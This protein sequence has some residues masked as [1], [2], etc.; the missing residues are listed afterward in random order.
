[1]FESD[2]SDMHFFKR[3]LESYYCIFILKVEKFNQGVILQ[4]NKLWVGGAPNGSV[5]LPE[6]HLFFY[7]VAVHVIVCR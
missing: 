2:L 3:H 4:K 1:M 7:L 6:P 5:G